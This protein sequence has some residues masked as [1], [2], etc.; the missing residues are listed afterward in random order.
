MI[1]TKR[2]ILRRMSLED[3]QD[4]YSVL[5]DGEVM[6]YI[7][8][9]FDMAGTLE[10]IKTAGLC[11]PPL[12][13]AVEWKENGRVIGHAVFHPY[14]KS[15]YEIGWILHHDYWGKGIADELTSALTARAIELK[16]A[17][18]VIECDSR[19]AASGRIAEKYDFIYDGSSGGLDIYRLTL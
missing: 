12:V 13:L 15:F 3:A 8:P 5:S 14:D 4:L 9:P 19:Q 18:C 7:E 11:E 1:T 10:F 17:D 2:C 16:A 6:K